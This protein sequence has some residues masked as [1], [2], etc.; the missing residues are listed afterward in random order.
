MPTY[1]YVVIREDGSEG[2]PFEVVQ[3]MTDDALTEHPE[4][5]EPVRRVIIAPNI[6]GD[7][8][9]GTNKSKLSDANLDRLGFIEGYHYFVAE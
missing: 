6:A 3:K 1:V 4:T 7:Y 5:G 2:E 9:E 8:S